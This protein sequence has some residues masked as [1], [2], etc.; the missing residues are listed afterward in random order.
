MPKL[1][2]LVRH[3]EPDTAYLRKYLG[4]MDP[5]LSPKGREQ[6]RRAAARIGRFCP[7]RIV[8]SPLRR[9]KDTA[10][11]I[12]D[13]CGL[14]CETDDL[15][16]EIDFGDLEGLSF[17]EASAI[18]PGATD[19]WQALSGDFMFP[20]G[21]DFSSFNRRAAA[22]ARQVRACPEK[23]VA[24]VAHGGILRGILCNLLA[25]EANGP[26]RFRLSYAAVTTLELYSDSA[27][28]LGFNVGREQETSIV[29]Q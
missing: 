19:S 12:A 24:L 28:L 13:A 7:D 11:V 23:S 25:V 10:D 29:P 15:L 8:A 20:G 6:A 18:F 22:M 3:A 1:V 14:C 5:G 4:R 16:L 9:A 27:A 17:K 26:L 2:H 21:E